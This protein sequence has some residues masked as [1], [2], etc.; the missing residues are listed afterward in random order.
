MQGI[1]QRRQWKI[2]L[3]GLASMAVI[4]V[5]AM[6][7]RRLS[8]HNQN[9]ASSPA[10]MAVSPSSPIM[11]TTAPEPDD[12]TAAIATFLQGP[13]SW[14]SGLQWS[15]EWGK[16]YYDGSS[17]GAFGCGLCCTAN[18]YCSLTDYRCSPV[19]MYNYAKRVTEYE[20]GGAIDWGYMK[21]TLT[22]AGFTCKVGKKPERY[23][24]F[25]SI[26]EESQAC[27]VVVSSND[28]TCYWKD[29][30]GHYVTLF[31]YDKELDKV[32]LADSGDPG[33]NRHWVSLNKIYRSL[34][35]AN[36][37]QYMSVLNYDEEKDQWK[38]K[39]INGNCVLPKEWQS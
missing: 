5:A 4:V 10:V 38:H 23:E 37:W 28:S 18:I 2:I 35:T 36:H 29:T 19:D 27:V 9:A 24:E 33:H 1:M 39:K 26:V 8:G 7:N 3:F 16:T 13:K 17:F 21:R 20:G 6:I 31:L 14:K 12:Q 30:P 32:F 11:E 34:K 25:Q 22:V 15:G